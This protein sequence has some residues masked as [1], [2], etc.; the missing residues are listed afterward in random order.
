MHM[1]HWIATTSLIL[2]MILASACTSFGKVGDLDTDAGTE[3]GSESEDG[4]DSDSVS[5]TT[6]NTSSGSDGSASES[7]SSSASGSASASSTATVTSAS[8]S[9][10]GETTGGKLCDGEGGVDAHFY[11]SH[12]AEFETFSQTHTCGVVEMT[13]EGASSSIVLD[14]GDLGADAIEY[15]IEHASIPGL[16]SHLAVDDLVSFHIA[17][18]VPFWTEQWFSIRDQEG[19]LLL[20]GG[21]GSQPVPD[22]FEDEQT[23]EMFAPFSPATTTDVCATYTDDCATIEPVLVDFG[24]GDLAPGSED[25]LADPEG[26]EYTVRLGQA[27]RYSEVMCTDF[28]GSWYELLIANVT[29]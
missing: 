12:E 10:T 8:G 26:N 6:G 24:N 21:A 17:Q 23:Q 11:I 3:G 27:A 9:D 4:S 16:S 28:P 25:L 14:C 20:A 22:Q 29:P 15:T 19:S 1:K 5:S 7:A 18:V 13:Q 2:P